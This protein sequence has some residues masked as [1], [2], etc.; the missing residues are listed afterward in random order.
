MTGGAAAPFASAA[1]VLPGGEPLLARVRDE[2][3]KAATSRMRFAL[4]YLFVPGLAPVWDALE[5][6]AADE[7][8]LLI[9]NTAGQ[10]TDEQRVAA[11]AAAAAPQARGGGFFAD[12]VA[13]GARTERARVLSETTTALR[14]NLAAVPREER[15]ARLL[16]GLARAITGGRLRVRVYTGGRLHAKAYLFEPR[17]DG[18]AAGGG[19]ALVGSSN[20]TLPASGNPTE[21]NVVLRDAGS[22]AAVGAWFDALW[23]EAHDV[24]RDL[25]MEL[26]R[27]WPLLRSQDP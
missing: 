12:D 23:V 22:V 1:D 20:L 10:P 13:G 6:S 25:V 8:H 27:A 4:G 26:S 24:S 3:A 17:R 2:A 11:A 9:G 7:I 18:G 5:A 19:V 15:Q 16:T 21:L 14:A